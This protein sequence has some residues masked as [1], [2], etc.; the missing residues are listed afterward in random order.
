MRYL[1]ATLAVLLVSPFSFAA[2][3]PA[4]VPA[5]KVDFDVADRTYACGRVL[6]VTKTTIL[7]DLE[8]KQGVTSFPFHDRLASGKVQQ[9]RV[10]ESSI[11]NR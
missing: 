11:L 5:R 9:G 10:G 2:D 3:K 6:A 1:C 7:I 4:E 8:R